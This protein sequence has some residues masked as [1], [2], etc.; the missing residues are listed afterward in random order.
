MLTPQA[1][2]PQY[3]DAIPCGAVDHFWLHL[4]LRVRTTS[5]K[6]FRLFLSFSSPFRSVLGLMGGRDVEQFH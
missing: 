3:H 4:R 1:T 6:L 5:L 2:V